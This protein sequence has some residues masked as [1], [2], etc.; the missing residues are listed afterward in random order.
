MNYPRVDSAKWTNCQ[1]GIVARYFA[2]EVYKRPVRCEKCGKTER[3][4]IHHKDKNR[5][6]NTNENLRVLCKKHHNEIHGMAVPTSQFEELDHGGIIQMYTIEKATVKEIMVKF[7]CSHHMVHRTLREAGV[8]LRK[9]Q[10]AMKILSALT[11]DWNG[12]T[13]REFS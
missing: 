1:L 3:L 8:P 10:R 4:E 12:D 6:N 11:R 13:R 5:M 2:F 7:N 9:S